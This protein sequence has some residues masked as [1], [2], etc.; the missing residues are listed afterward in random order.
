MLAVAEQS[1]TKIR[2]IPHPSNES[3]TIASVAERKESLPSTKALLR[4]EAERRNKQTVLRTVGRDSQDPSSL[5]LSP[6]MPDA[7]L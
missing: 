1:E 5:H 4:G 2:R 3:P 6:N 7:R